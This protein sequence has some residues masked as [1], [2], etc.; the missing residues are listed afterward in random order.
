MWPIGTP[1]S[2]V[3][4]SSSQSSLSPQS[5]SLHPECINYLTCNFCTEPFS[6]Y[7]FSCPFHPEIK[8]C[9]DCYRHRIVC[10]H[11]KKEM[12][13]SLQVE[14]MLGMISITCAICS[15]SFR[16]NEYS[17][18]RSIC[19]TKGKYHCA[20]E[21]GEIR[22]SF[23]TEKPDWIF[24]HYLIDHQVGEYNSLLD[25]IILPHVQLH[26]NLREIEKPFK[27]VTG[28]P[29][30]CSLY[31]LYL[32]NFQ[33]TRVILEFAYRITSRSYLFIA[34]S[35]KVLQIQLQ[36][37]VPKHSV[38]GISMGIGNDEIDSKEGKT[39]T[40]ANDISLYMTQNNMIR[41]VCAFE[42]DV[43]DMYEKYSMIH[44]DCRF[45]QFGVKIVR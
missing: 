8:V 26:F 4:S 33:G 1:S 32:L 37:L 39:V 25:T 9:P 27:N 18:H 16:M 19:E 21:I 7:V 6:G 41:S 44:G 28:L 45:A 10:C 2:Q 24:S 22:C 34:R 20:Y 40:F 11:C 42:I 30:F 36:M 31:Y 38:Y 43:F 35:D 14:E 3:H 15:Q 13:R 29:C 23:S 5:F 17:K 12:Q